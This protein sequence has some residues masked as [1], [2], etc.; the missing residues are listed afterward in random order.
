MTTVTKVIILGI[1]RTVVCNGD[2]TMTVLAEHVNG[3]DYME[4]ERPCDLEPQ[5]CTC[6]TEILQ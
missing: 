6:C 5:H 3:T 4:Y 2:G 1:E